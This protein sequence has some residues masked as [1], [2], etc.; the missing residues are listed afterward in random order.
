MG[1]SL[2]DFL[3]DS[4]A[5]ASQAGLRAQE[6][7]AAKVW[8]IEA[9]A[10]EELARQIQAFAHYETTLTQELSCLRQAK[11]DLKKRIFDKGQ[12]YTE[13]KSKVLP[14]RTR[15]VELEEEAEETKT[16]I[17]K[18]EER[19]VSREVQLG[20]VEGDLAEKTEHFQKAEAELLEG[21]RCLR[22][23]V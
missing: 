21:R 23:R 2:M 19:V 14:L 5:F 4:F 13:L 16:K 12:E 10:K 20:R 22:K 1:L 15:V 11:K 3:T 8:E 6:D 9:K 17:A 7:L 18:L